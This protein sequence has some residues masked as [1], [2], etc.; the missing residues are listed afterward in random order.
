MNKEDLESKIFFKKYQAVGKIG[1]GS[2]GQIYRGKRFLYL[3]KNIINP[4]Q[5]FAIKLVV[6]V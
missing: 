3:A 2:F 6:L 5:L 1:E 4:E